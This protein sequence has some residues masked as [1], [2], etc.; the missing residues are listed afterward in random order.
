MA[1]VLLETSVRTHPKFLAAGP[2]AS[3][4]WVC[5]LGYCQDGLTDGFIPDSAIEYLGVKRPREL[6][7]KLVSVRLW[8][9]APG[10][11][12]M[13]D[14][15]DHNKAAEEVRQIRKRR[16]EGGK[17]GGRPKK[18]PSE[19]LTGNLQGF[20]S[21]AEPENLPENP[22]RNVTVRNV[23]VRDGTDDPVVRVQRFVDHW[24]V[25][26]QAERGVAY[27]GHPHKDYRAACELVDAFADDMLDAIAIRGLRDTDP[28]MTK[29]TLT[30]TKLKSQ[31]SKYAQDE[32]AARAQAAA[33]AVD[34][35]EECKQLH[36]GA[37]EERLRHH[38]QMLIDAERQKGVAS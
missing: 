11:W 24:G 38:H 3:W 4:L 30:L 7:R 32:L 29:G 5:G 20:Q 28:F 22:V 37:C 8:E 34:W 25:T 33:P 14:Y 21:S 6:A 26:Y 12:Q 2:E 23:P 19:P 36:G 17:L 27:L 13:H 15:L 35:W 18:E 31:A 16:G 1:Y 10:G 9:I